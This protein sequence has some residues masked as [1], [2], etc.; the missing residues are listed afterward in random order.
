VKE[1][2]RRNEL[3]ISKIVV[4]GNQKESELLYLVTVIN[5]LTYNMSYISLNGHCNLSVSFA[6]ITQFLQKFTKNIYNLD[7]MNGKNH[8]NA[9]EMH[10]YRESLSKMRSNMK[11][12]TK[13]K[14]VRR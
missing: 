5:F 12:I 2:L 11:L 8:G 6:K 3:D 9:W 14:Y 13:R 4:R 10:T 1:L 7:F